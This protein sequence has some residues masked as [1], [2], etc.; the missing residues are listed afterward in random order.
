M[1]KATSQKFLLV[2]SVL[3]ENVGRVRFKVVGLVAIIFL[4][5]FLFLVPIYLDSELAQARVEDGRKPMLAPRYNDYFLKESHRKTHQQ[6][7]NVDRL[8]LQPALS[9]LARGQPDRAIGELKFVLRYVPNHPKALQLMGVVA[10]LK[11]KPKIAQQY[12]EQAVRV[13]PKYAL[14]HAQFGKFLVDIGHL[15][16]G[17]EELEKAQALEPDLVTVFVWLAEAY[18]EN[19][20]VKKAKKA[21]EKAKE[22]GYEKKDS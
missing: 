6:V 12:F 19:G 8:H 21:E 4:G 18:K 13:F 22:L 3:I 14:T 11:K 15:E 20:D 7:N 5:F 9:H 10:R 16:H 2:F 17:I 1:F